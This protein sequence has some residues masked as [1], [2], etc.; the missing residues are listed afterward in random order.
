MILMY[1]GLTET[2]GGLSR[3]L[4][5]GGETEPRSPKNVRLRVGQSGIDA[6]GE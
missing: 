1:R 2:T 5:H 3:P 4:A 6:R